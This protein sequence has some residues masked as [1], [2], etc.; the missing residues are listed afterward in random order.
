[1]ISRFA[2]NRTKPRRWCRLFH[3]QWW[4]SNDWGT[5]YASGRTSFEIECQRCGDCWTERQQA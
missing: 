4:L 2:V 3:R 1:M 5:W